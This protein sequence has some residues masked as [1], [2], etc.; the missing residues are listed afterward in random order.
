M[1]TDSTCHQ[2]RLVSNISGLNIC[3]LDGVRSTGQQYG[4]KAGVGW[5]PVLE[6]RTTGCTEASGWRGNIGTKAPERAGN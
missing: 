5:E 6:R 3:Q 2:A 4:G 1:P